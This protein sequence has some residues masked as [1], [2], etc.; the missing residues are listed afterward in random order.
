M[1]INKLVFTI[2][3]YDYLIRQGSTLFFMLFNY[4]DPSLAVYCNDGDFA[5]GEDG[6]VK[7][8]VN[9]ALASV[10]FYDDDDWISASDICQ[11]SGLGRFGK[12][13]K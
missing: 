6:L 12:V 1:E 8:C 10:C 7:R 11:F 13:K 5:I 2:T 4:P 9:R 3:L